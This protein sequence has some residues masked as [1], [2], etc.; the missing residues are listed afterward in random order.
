MTYAKRLR[1]VFALLA[2]D[3]R[4]QVVFT[5]APH[6]FGEGVLPYL[7]RM[8]ITVIPWKEAVRTEFDLAL[9]AGSRGMELIKAPLIRMSHGAGHIKLL[10]EAEGATAGGLRAAGMLSSQYLMREGRVVPAALAL[11]H[12]LALDVLA[13]S[14]PQALP[15]ATVVGDPDF[16]GITA[17][18][19]RRAAYRRALGLEEGQRLVLITSTWGRSSSFGHVGTLLPRLVR[20]LPGDTYRTAL[21]VH[22]NVWAG[23]GRWQILAWLARC[24]EHG[25]VLLP[26][27]TDWRP[28]L[29]AADWIIGDHGSV[30]VYGTLTAASILLASYPAGEVSLDSPAALLARTVPALSPMHPL[31]E[32]L[33]YAAE[34]RDPAE[35]RR[36]ADLLTSE[37]GRFSQRM[38]TLVYQQLG[39]GEPA[40][41]PDCES[42]T[43]P[44]PL[45]SWTTP[46]R[47]AAV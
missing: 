4:I 30:T 44:D 16:D 42:P 17:G 9:T 33:Q 3:L 35:Y 31:R 40:V 46:R 47:D 18:L 22:P 38:R 14:C 13:R 41:A 39:L 34:R 7:Q 21:L 24:R 2:A 6:A 5:V 37:P 11:S 8:G 12:R 36:V 19:G 28:L 1:H 10:R 45:D 43:L 20:E 15:V 26:P 27:E 23:H 32:Q 25:V 29:T